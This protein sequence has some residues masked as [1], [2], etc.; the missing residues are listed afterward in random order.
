[1]PDFCGA[2][3]GEFF[4]SGVGFSEDADGEG[5]EEFVGDDEGLVAGC[6]EGGDEGAVPGAFL[7][8]G[9]LLP[10]AEV[11][12]D[13]DEVVVELAAFEK[14]EGGADVAG[15]GAIS[16]AA[17]DDGEGF[18]ECLP[19]EGDPARDGGGERLVELRGGGEIPP[20]AED[21]AGGG[22][23]SARAV[24]RVGHELVEADGGII[25]GHRPP[26]PIGAEFS[27]EVFAGLDVEFSGSEDGDV[28]DG[29]DDLGA[30]E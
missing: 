24:K 10:L 12:G 25:D 17:L 6:F 13:L 18:S 8:E 27:D 15:E 9:F 7:G 20:V 1:M 4:E 29:K 22:V 14:G 23:V 26:L 30:P 21:G 3:E 2:L 28:V 11:W 19:L 5:V 16:R